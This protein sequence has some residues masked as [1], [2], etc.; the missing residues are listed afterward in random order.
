G[1]VAGRDGPGAAATLRGGAPGARHPGG[2]DGPYL[3]WGGQEF[4]LTRRR[5]VNECRN[6]VRRGDPCPHLSSVVPRCSVTNAPR[7]CPGS[8]TRPIATT[9]RTPRPPHWL[10]AAAPALTMRARR[11][12]RGSWWAGRR[13]RG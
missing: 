9:W 1:V 4:R 10:P 3:S 6:T 8:P 12:G 13:W 11:A 5:W 7:C 2:G